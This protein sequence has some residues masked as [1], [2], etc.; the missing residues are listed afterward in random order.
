MNYTMT[1]KAFLLVAFACKKLR[2]YL[3]GSYAIDF[4]N[5]TTPRHLLSKM[6]AKLRFV[7]WM[8]IL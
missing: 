5:H 1:E 8:L 7:R 2:P 4:A 6:D 3:I